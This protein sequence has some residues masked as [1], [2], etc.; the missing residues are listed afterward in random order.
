LFRVFLY[1]EF[2]VLL[3]KV[4]PLIYFSYCF[5][6]SV[7]W[8]LSSM[9]VCSETAENTLDLSSSGYS[10]SSSYEESH[11]LRLGF[12]LPSP[13]SISGYS[14]TGVNPRKGVLYSK[15]RRSLVTLLKR[16]P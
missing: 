8:V 6:D 3:V 5:F 9:S 4:F 12:D 1:K 11:R 16:L 7:F 14:V 13:P 10:P 2:S 15:V